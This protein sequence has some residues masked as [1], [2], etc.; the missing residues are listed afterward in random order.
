[1]SALIEDLLAFSRVGKGKLAQHRLV[2]M[3]AQVAALIDELDLQG[4]VELADIPS[5]DGDPAMLRQ[6][7]Q[8]LILNALKF[9]RDASQPLVKISGKPMHDGNAEFSVEDNGVGFDMLHAD[10]LFGV[11][12]RLHSERDFEGTGVGLA[13][14]H[15]IISRHGGRISAQ[16]APGKGAKF[17]FV[18]PE[19]AVGV[20]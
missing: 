11:F 10:K 17:T 20:G 14:V 2:D 18:L 3:H 7:W 19:G 8:N 6:V 4:K 5:V 12:Q 1:M 9:S 13:I 16:S 15:R